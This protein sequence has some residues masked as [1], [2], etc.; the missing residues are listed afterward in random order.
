MTNFRCPFYGGVRL[1]EVLVLSRCP[2]YRGVCLKEMSVKR[3]STV[4]VTKFSLYLSFTVHYIYTTCQTDPLEL[5]CTLS[6]SFP[7]LIYIVNLNLT[8]VFTVKVILT[9]Y[10]DFQTKQQLSPLIKNNK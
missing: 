9:L 8:S 2:C 4:L 10:N 1:I 5:C 6:C 3:E 7:Y